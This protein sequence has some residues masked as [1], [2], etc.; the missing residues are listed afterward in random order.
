M[1]YFWR[2]VVMRIRTAAEEVMCVAVGML[3][4]A[5]LR[6]AASHDRSEQRTARLPEGSGTRQTDLTHCGRRCRWV[7]QSVLRWNSR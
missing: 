6:S 5:A 4:A 2:S 7:M 1:Q 3:L